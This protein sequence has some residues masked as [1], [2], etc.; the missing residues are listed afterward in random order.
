MDTRIQ[1][2]QEAHDG[3]ATHF[4][5]DEILEIVAVV[6]NMNIWTRLKLAERAMPTT[7]PPV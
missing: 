3:M 6:I 7:A 4:T 2:V 1:N 5:E